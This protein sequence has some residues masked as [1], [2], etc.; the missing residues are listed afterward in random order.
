MAA[1]G[2]LPTSSPARTSTFGSSPPPSPTATSATPAASRWPSS[3]GRRCTGGPH[4]RHP[5]HHD[6]YHRHPRGAL[7]AGATT[8]FGGSRS[9]STSA[10]V[11]PCRRSRRP[12]W[13]RLPMCPPSSDGGSNPGPH[14]VVTR[15]SRRSP[16]APARP[17]RR[18][19]A[20]ADGTAHG[21]PTRHR[22]RPWR[23]PR[24][25]PRPDPGPHA[26]AGHRGAHARADPFGEPSPTQNRP[27]SRRQPPS[28][29]GPRPA[30]DTHPNR[31]TGAHRGALNHA[32]TRAR[33]ARP[34]FRAFRKAV[35]NSRPGS[36]QGG[37]REPGTG[38]AGPEEETPT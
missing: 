17:P 2:T 21:G 1:L 10:G 22:R 4:H 37:W 9:S 14:P 12:L 27:R 19:H 6:R 5:R 38:P 7:V 16:S 36:T 29:G 11:I 31:Y 35:G 24:R 23:R 28:R 33:A 20:S 18:A 8:L 25:P 13:R 26:A 32:V 34:S 30:A 3:S 15:R